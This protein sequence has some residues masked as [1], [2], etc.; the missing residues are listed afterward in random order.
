MVILNY[1]IPENIIRISNKRSSRATGLYFLLI[2][3]HEIYWRM[4]FLD[5]FDIDF[6]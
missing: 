6:C 1:K 4:D 5:Q 3:N 2:F